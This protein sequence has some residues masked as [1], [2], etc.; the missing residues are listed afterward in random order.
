MERRILEEICHRMGMKRALTTAYYPQAD[1][2]TK[3]MNQ[4]LK[5]S[6]QAYIGPDR[7][8]WVSSLDGLALSYNSMPH[9]AT[10]FVPSYLLGGYVPITRSSLIHLPGSIQ[11]PLNWTELQLFAEHR[12]RM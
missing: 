6:L 4:T 8:D 1:G 10:G 2:Q 11:R 9:T 5:I 3:I 7:D 12:A